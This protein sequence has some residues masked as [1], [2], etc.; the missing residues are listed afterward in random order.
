MMVIRPLKICECP[1]CTSI[2]MKF[3]NEK[4]IITFALHN[5]QKNEWIQFV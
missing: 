1:I 5:F 4:I 2:N 3:E